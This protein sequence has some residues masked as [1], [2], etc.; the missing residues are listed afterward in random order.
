MKE[1]HVAGEKYKW[2]WEIKKWW[3]WF[4]Y[5]HITDINRMVM[6]YGICV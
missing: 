1:I 3:W 2:W 4:V 6:A 5:I